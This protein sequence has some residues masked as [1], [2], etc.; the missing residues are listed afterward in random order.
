[1]PTC[2][3]SSADLFA[4]P[5]AVTL[6]GPTARAGALRIEEAKNRSQLVGIKIP[7]K[8]SI[9]RFFDSPGEA[10]IGISIAA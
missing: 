8:S 6:H 2:S 5:A 1:L 4:A 7:K 10:E 3:P 9:L